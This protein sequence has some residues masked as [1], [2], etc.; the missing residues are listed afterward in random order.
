M[1]SKKNPSEQK[2]LALVVGINKYEYSKFK[3]LKVPANNARY[4]AN[5]LIE[6]GD[7]EVET[8]NK[9]SRKEL[10]ESIVQLFKPK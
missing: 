2:R 10:K 8:F 4:I 1:N 9:V 7:C 5:R 6:E 3:N